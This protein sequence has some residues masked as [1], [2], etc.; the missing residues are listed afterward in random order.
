MG[1]VV[2]ILWKISLKMQCQ[3]CLTYVVR[4]MLLVEW[5]EEL[6]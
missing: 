5:K 1:L 3:E 6:V 2:C 4:T